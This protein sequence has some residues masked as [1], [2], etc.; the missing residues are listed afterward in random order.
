[1][2]RLRDAVALGFLVCAIQ[3]ALDLSLF[4]PLL[5]GE[6][7]QHGPAC[8]LKSD[9]LGDV[10]VLF[11]VLMVALRVFCFRIYFSLTLFLIFLE[12]LGNPISK[13]EKISQKRKRS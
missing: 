13:F 12:W 2:L 5:H 10:Q 4:L 3:G 1:M 6:M 7:V 9:K 8:R 11:L